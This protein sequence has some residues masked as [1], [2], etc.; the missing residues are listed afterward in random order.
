QS[1]KK[2]MQA[3]GKQPSYFQGRQF[4]ADSNYYCLANLALCQTEQF[5]AYLPDFQ[6]RK[7]DPRFHE[8]HRFKPGVHSRRRSTKKATK[9]TAAD[10]RFDALRQIYVCLQGNALK[11]GARN[12]HNRYRL[13]DI[14]RAHQKDGAACPVQSKCL[15]KPG[16]ARRF[17]SVELKKQSPTLL[18]QMKAKIDTPYGRQVYARRLAIVEPVFANLRIHKRL[19]PFTLRSKAKVDVQWKL[20]ALVHN[21]GK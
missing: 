4:T 10:F 2:N 19:D 17:L 20:C 3:I 1:A 13:Y 7:R 21:I 5:D 16:T 11:C 9:F 6:F 8:Q 14:Y 15:S 18:E 12:Q